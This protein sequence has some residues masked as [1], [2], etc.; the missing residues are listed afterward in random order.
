MI[1]YTTRRTILAIETSCDETAAAVI[2][3]GLTAWMPKE[4]GMERELLCSLFWRFTC[5]PV[6]AI[7]AALGMAEELVERAVETVRGLRRSS[8]AWGRQVRIL[9]WRVRCLLRSGPCRA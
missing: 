7:G 2:R 9:E 1:E 5:A 4:H 3:E 6:P 8:E